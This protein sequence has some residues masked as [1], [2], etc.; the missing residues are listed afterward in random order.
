MK[1]FTIENET[2]NITVHAS[3]KE[4]EAVPNSERF[5]TEATLAKLAANWP[6]ARLVEIYNSLP[7]ETP[8]RKFKDR[9]TAVSRIWKALQNLG[10]TAPAAE[11][12]AQAPEVLPVAEVAETAPVPE[13]EASEAAQPEAVILESTEPAVAATLAPHAP[14][15]ASS[16]P[17]AKKKATRAKRAPIAASAKD[18]ATP[19]EGSKTSQVIAMLK[20]EGG[21]TLEEITTAMGW[22]KHTTRAMLSAG[23]SIT[24][25]HGLVVTSEKVG[26]KR[27]YS[28]K[29]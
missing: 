17:A 28:I 6:A 3:A 16:E 23:G 15:V 5:G 2:N 24:K 10:Q 11:E 25:N 13:P 29:S 20:R 9:A 14:D 22:Q 18:A 8:V 26:D 27:T 21:T 7:G 4:A 1:S 19:R 12:P